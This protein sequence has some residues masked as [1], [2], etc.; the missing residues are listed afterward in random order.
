MARVTI[1]DVTIEDVPNGAHPPPR[2]GNRQVN[3]R[4]PSVL[5]LA[6]QLAGPGTADAL[7]ERLWPETVAAL[8]ERLRV[9]ES[10][11]ETL[12]GW[13]ERGLWHASTDDVGEFL[14]R[15]AATG[16]PEIARVLYIERHRRVPEFLSAILAAADPTDPRW[17]AAGGLVPTVLE[18]PGGLELEPALHGPFPELVEH[19]VLHLG[20]E[21]PLPVVLDAC[22]HLARLAGAPAIG[23]LAKSIAATA[24]ELAHPGLAELLRSAAAAP[25]PGSFLQE[26]RPAGEWTDPAHAHALLR[27]RMEERDV[28][29]PAG[30]GWELILRE[31]DRRPFGGKR[32]PSENR[33]ANPLVHLVGWEGCPDELIGECLPNSSWAV[34]HAGA[35]MSFEEVARMWTG[36]GPDGRIVRHGVLTGHLDRVLGELTPA[37]DVLDALPYDHEPT[38]E[39]VAALVAPLGADPV[40]WLTFYARMGRTDGTAPELIADAASADSPKKRTATWPRP[41]E[42]VFPVTVPGDSRAVFLNVLQ[43]AP[44]AVQIAVV[45][46]LD[47]RAVQHFLV[48]G[49]PAPAVRE[50]LV[51]THG[52]P[53]LAS[54]A[55][56]RKLP[57][58][59]L[60][61]LLDLDEPAVDANLFAHCHI[62]QRERERMLAGRLRGGGTRPAVPGELLDALDE[63]NLGHYRHWLIAGLESGDLGVARKIVG[64]LRFAIPAARLRLL[65]AVWERGGP[66]A[67]REILAMDRLPVTLRRQTEKLL[68]APDGLERLRDR[69]AAEEDPAKLLAHPPS[70]LVG[71]GVPLPWAALMEAQRTGRLADHL[72]AALAEL[73]DCPR[74]IRL[75]A[76]RSTPPAHP[77]GFYDRGNWVWRTLASGALAP[78][79]LLAHAAPA[80]AALHHLVEAAT[81]SSATD[82][83]ALR[84]RVTA[85]TDAHLGGNADAWAVCLQLLPTFAGTLT[86]LISTAGAVARV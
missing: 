36:K 65:T 71:D 26:R 57:D 47:A 15:A 2:E 62:D 22:L 31:H 58:A 83:Q 13:E 60:E 11:V 70:R 8:S 69:L 79:D 55:S 53:A 3:N 64:R 54:Y 16:D 12:T 68:D 20:R 41:L 35:R 37:R 66:D 80:Q 61:Y 34:L 27:V 18:N 14:L 28:E 86:E 77:R 82:R 21:L 42:A 75:A 63:V 72:P 5:G 38:R 4:P 50:A 33:H 67:V 7:A 43:C 81:G 1:E 19:A 44:E 56:S 78:E 73:A 49:D 46:H 76:L 74:E 40:N 25:D 6:L 85:L 9:P 45:P 17:Y 30:L 32:V 51:A 10:A 24:D 29:Q 23:N 48:Y 39:A 59:T 84:A 52:V